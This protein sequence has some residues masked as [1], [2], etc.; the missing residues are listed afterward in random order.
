MKITLLV[1]TC[2]TTLAPALLA[3]NQ[4]RPQGTRA[5]TQQTLPTNARQF[6]RLKIPGDEVEKN[7]RRLTKELR[8]YKTLGAA[9]GSA[10]AKGRPVLW[11]QALGELKGFL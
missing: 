1:L 9:L 8:W 5:A 6:R 4:D 2:C 3:Q 7:V 10:R 11:V